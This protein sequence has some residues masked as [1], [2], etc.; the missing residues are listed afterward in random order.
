MNSDALQPTAVRELLASLVRIPS[1]NPTIAPEEAHGEAAI[2]AFACRWLEER[3][4]KARIEEAT[5]GRPNAVAEVANRDST[6]IVRPRHPDSP[7]LAAYAGTPG[8]TS[9]GTPAASSRRACSCR[10]EYTD[11]SPEVS[12]LF[13]PDP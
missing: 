13:P 10:A 1:V 11:G 8:V 7:N 5:P 4:V 3:G 9:Q 6:T 2:A 12:H